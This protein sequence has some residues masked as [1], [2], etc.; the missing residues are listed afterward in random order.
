MSVAVKEVQLDGRLIHR[1]ERH[2]GEEVTVFFRIPRRD[3]WWLLRRQ[4]RIHGHAAICIPVGE[5]EARKRT[6][7]E[8]EKERNDSRRQDAEKATARKSE[9]GSGKQVHDRKRRRDQGKR[10]NS[11]TVSEKR[12][13]RD[14][15]SKLTEEKKKWRRTEEKQ[16]KKMAELTAQ[17]ERKQQE[18][19]RAL[20]E[21]PMDV[22]T[23]VTNCG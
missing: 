12:T 8:E 13:K 16:K 2:E 9:T 4:E 11:S 6:E 1:L 19:I 14:E 3:A 7:E 5:D 15:A 18:L 10:R 23:G 17:L 22:S 20:R 21:E